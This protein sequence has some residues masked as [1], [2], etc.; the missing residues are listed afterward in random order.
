MNGK[1]EKIDIRVGNILLIGSYSAAVLLIAGLLVLFARTPGAELESKPLS[2]SLFFSYVKENNPL[3]LLNL[4]I[5][6]MML[7]PLFRVIAAGFSFFL[8]KDY[9]YLVIASGVLIILLAT[10][11]SIFI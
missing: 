9:K 5:L 1:K 4:G 8:E 7:T 3:A 10:I 6:V 11:I 2:F